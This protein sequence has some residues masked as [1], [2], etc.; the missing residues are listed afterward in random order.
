MTKTAACI[1]GS[2]LIMM[3]KVRLTTNINVFM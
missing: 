2:A 3:R 1:G